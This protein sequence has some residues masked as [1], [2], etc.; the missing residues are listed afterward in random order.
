MLGVRCGW[1]AVYGVGGDNGRELFPPATV[2]AEG[3][4]GEL[5]PPKKGEAE[6]GSCFLPKREW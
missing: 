5:L 3:D 2:W 6:G 1:R 4:G